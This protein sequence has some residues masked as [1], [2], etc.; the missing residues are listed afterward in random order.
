[1]LPSLALILHEWGAIVWVGGMFFALIVL[2]PAT[3]PLDP[4][5]RLAL[6]RRVF[7]CM[8]DLLFIGIPLTIDL[9]QVIG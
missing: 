3:G 5:A 8:V 7:A 6:W 1:M 9:Q 2:R 4:P